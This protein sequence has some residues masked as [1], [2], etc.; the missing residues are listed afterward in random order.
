MLGVP[1]RS[2]QASV[3]TDQ[4]RLERERMLVGHP[5]GEP[6][7]ETST[8]PRVDP[9]ERRAR[10]AAEPFQAAAD[11]D[12]DPQR[13]HINRD[14]AD[15]L[16]AVDDRDRPDPPRLLRDRRDVVDDRPT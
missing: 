6:G 14:R 2:R 11:V 10:T 1:C 3:A 12:V 16:V 9:E 15:G 5:A 7:L 4:L 8:E 13:A